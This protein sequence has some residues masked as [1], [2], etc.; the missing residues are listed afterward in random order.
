MICS[1]FT[2]TSANDVHFQAFLLEGMYCWN[3]DREINVLMAPAT[4]PASYDL[5]LTST[6]NELRSSVLWSQLHPIFNQLCQYTGNSTILA[7]LITIIC[8][9]FFLC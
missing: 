1:I 6:I 5:S 9:S 4:A 2:G 7:I 8:L 3:K